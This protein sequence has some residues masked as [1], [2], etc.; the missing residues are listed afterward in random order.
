MKKI[1][2]LILFFCLWASL[3]WSRV[4]I[5]IEAPGQLRMPIAISTFISKSS[6]QLG[7]KAQTILKKDLNFTGL[8]SILSP[9][10]FL[11]EEPTLEVDFKKWQLI[12][13][14]LLIK[15]K[16]EVKNGLVHLDL[17][18]YDVRKGLQLLGKR[19]KG[20]PQS[21]RYMIHKFAD[22]M[23][24]A[25][26]GEP[27]IFQTK[28]AFVYTTKTGKEIYLT[29]FDG[30]HPR[31]LT[32]FR[33]ICLSPRW[34]PKG[35]KLLF[36]SYKRG[37]PD[38][39]LVDLKQ[40]KAFRIIHYPGLNIAPAWSPSGEEIAVTLSKTGKQGIYL[41]DNNGNII[42]CLTLS[43]GINVS[44]TWS[45]DRKKLA[46]VSDRSGSPQIYI[47]DLNSNRIKRLTFEGHYNTSP[48]WSPKGNFIVYSSLKDG[49][50]QL[51]M[52]K[53]DGSVIKQLTYDDA[54][55]ESPSWSPDGHFI[56]F[57][58]NGR[59]CVLRLG[60]GKI[61]SIVDLPGKQTQPSWSPRLK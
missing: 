59:I 21:V 50:F 54:N 20:P 42:K 43:S 26:T 61:F 5:D 11:E 44:P 24:E 23:M 34:H 58:Q 52:I 51:F 12:G 8:F 37:K 32:R 33:S 49:H 31:P 16:L 35:D 60:D 13:A 39:Y 7:F 53:S 30:Y 4:Y 57:S 3:G 38:V 19:Y 46:F 36:T 18:L 45:P 9:E 2:I 41:V 56:A 17:R 14:Y 55:H 15:G 29:D 28:I 1:S 40:R 48:A 47:L 10:I 25:L 22:A 27:S 6:P